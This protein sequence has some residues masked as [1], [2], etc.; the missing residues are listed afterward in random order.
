MSLGLTSGLSF[1]VA[2][3]ASLAATPGAI[4]IA[5]RT[6]FLDRP[7][8]YRQH[9]APTPFLGGA[10]VLAAFILAGLVVSGA[11]GKLL[12]PLGCAVCLWLLGT[13]DDRVAVAP[14]WRVLAE[15]LAASALYAAGLGWETR[16]PDVFDFGLTIISVVIA[17]NAFNLMDNLDGACGAVTAMAASGIGVLAAIRGD[18]AVAGLSFALAGACAGFL[19]F[20]LARPSRIFLGDGGSMPAGFLVAALAMT[21]ARHAAGG[22]AGLLLGALLAG[23][24]IFDTAL[25]SFSRTRRGVTLVTGGRD[26]FTHRLLLSLRSPWAVAIAL[27]VVQASL[28]ALAIVGYELGSEA[29]AWIALAAFVCGVVA[30]LVLDSPGWRPAGIAVGGPEQPAVLVEP[31]VSVEPAAGIEEA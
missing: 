29:V 14:F 27:A 22:N 30:I 21:T 25:V 4:K 3:A 18:A 24:P 31:A 9:S 15:V 16:L 5:E 1:A 10:A 2:G 13:M 11:S 7:R 6:D 26:H 12:V 23:V 19:P 8:E 17:V 20:N 28:S